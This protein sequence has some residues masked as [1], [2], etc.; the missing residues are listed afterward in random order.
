MYLKFEKYLCVL[1]SYL[2][3]FSIILWIDATSE[4]TIVQSLKDIQAKYNHILKDPFLSSDQNTVLDWISNYYKQEW[5]LIY[6]N[7][8]HDNISLL[9]R[10]MP[11]GESGNILITSRNPYLDRITDNVKEAVSEMCLAEALEFFFK[12]SYLQ[13]SNIDIY[14]HAKA[15]VTRLGFI[16]LAI[17]LAGSSISGDFYTIHDYIKL[18]DKNRKVIFKKTFSTEQ[19]RNIYE[20]WNMSLNAIQNQAKRNNA[21]AQYALEILELLLFFY[22]NNISEEIFHRASISNNIDNNYMTNNVYSKF[23]LLTEDKKWDFDNFKSGIH[24]LLAS[25]LLKKIKK[26][27]YFIYSLHPLVHLWCID[28]LDESK[29]QSL[30]EAAVIIM[31]KAV[32]TEWDENDYIFLQILSPHL[33]HNDFDMEN[34]FVNKQ[35]ATSWRHNGDWQRAEHMQYRVLQTCKN[36]FQENHY[37]T[38]QAMGDLASIYWNQGRWEEA[39][40]LYLQVLTLQKRVLGEEHPDILQAMANLACTYWNQGRWKEAEELDLQVLTLQKRVL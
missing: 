22:Y 14:E 37:E 18:L 30:L 7:A 34:M 13:N 38:F 26:E 6:D 40:D 8:D 39:E 31:A 10:Y 32:P 17:D 27:K 25:S 35:F 16:P 12:A 11:A 4:S 29:K 33:T 28:G 2:F 24:I 5:L 20:S 21:D 1:N 9:K 15:I 3:S 23:L 19:E 36:K